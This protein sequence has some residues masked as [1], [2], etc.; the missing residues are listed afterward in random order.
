MHTSY[1]DLLKHNPKIGTILDAETYQFLDNSNKKTQDV[2]LDMWKEHLRANLDLLEKHG[3]VNDGLKG[4]GYNKAT[5][6]I[7]A[8][9]SLHRHTERLKNLCHWNSQFPTKIQPFIFICSNH[10][11]KPYLEDGIIPHFVMLVDASE[12][13]AIY[14]QLCKNIPRRGHNT[15]LICSLYANPKLTH[16]WD[17]RGGIIQFYAPMVA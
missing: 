12:S 16:E 11:F 2:L 4:F 13:D 6:A 8:G 10:Q 15:V 3:F 7:G 5:I 9:P 14:D 1:E 17:R